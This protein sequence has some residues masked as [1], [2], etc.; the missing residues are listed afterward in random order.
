RSATP[1]TGR[2]K[3][4]FAALADVGVDVE[5]VVYE[6]DVLDAVRTSAP[7][8]S[9]R[10][11]TSMNL[12]PGRGTHLRTFISVLQREALLPRETLVYL[13]Q[14]PCAPPRTHVRHSY[15]PEST[16]RATVTPA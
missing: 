2:F 14:S 13:A 9:Q 16:V 1:E 7:H 5:P 8:S 11:S 4:V 12:R 3:A 15:R 6:D 10:Y